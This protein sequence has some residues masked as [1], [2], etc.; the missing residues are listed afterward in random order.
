MDLHRRQPILDRIRLDRAGVLEL[1][2]AVREPDKDYAEIADR[3]VPG[4]GDYLHPWDLELLVRDDLA[5]DVARREVQRQKAFVGRLVDL[6]PTLLRYFKLKT[7][8]DVLRTVHLIDDCFHDFPIIKSGPRRDRAVRDGISAIERAEKVVG[9][10]ITALAAL[11]QFGVDIDIERFRRSYLERTGDKSSGRFFN[12]FLEDLRLH[13][14]LLQ[15]CLIRAKSE[16]D[17]LIVSDNQAKTHIVETAYWL[18]VWHEGPPL[19]TTP[20]SDFSFICSLLYEIV[21]GK[22]N[23]SLAGA[24]NRFAR[25]KVR[26]EIDEGEREEKRREAID[27]TDN[28]FAVKEEAGRA[29]KEAQVYATLLEKASALGDRPRYM[30]AIML[31]NAIKRATSARDKYGPHIVWASQM[32]ANKEDEELME[33]LLTAR[34]MHKREIIALGERRRRKRGRG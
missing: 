15:I 24:I 22:T 4:A 14:D 26:L 19:V 6:L 31:E 33:R 28:F 9:Q 23:E 18:S 16:D 27:D 10:A 8:A 1:L 29:A 5:L 3:L 25:S 32:P 21:G 17:Y 30:I 7:K 2:R 11:Q 34:E 12:V 13:H 20:S